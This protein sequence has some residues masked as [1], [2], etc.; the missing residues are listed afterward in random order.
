MRFVRYVVWL[1]VVNLLV[2]TCWKIDHNVW[3]K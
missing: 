1:M 2:R 3:G